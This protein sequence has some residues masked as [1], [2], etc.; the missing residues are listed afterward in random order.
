LRT[1]FLGS[2]FF[3]HPMLILKE[4]LTQSAIRLFKT[5]LESPIQAIFNYEI[6]LLVKYL[7]VKISDIT[8][9][10]CDEGDDPL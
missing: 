10:G 6:G 9:V 2:Y 4:N 5:L 7:L 8:C 1:N 3:G